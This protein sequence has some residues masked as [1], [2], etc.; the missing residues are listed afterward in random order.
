MLGVS[1]SEAV[2][3]LLPSSL[4]LSVVQ[5]HGFR[6]KIKI[7][8]GI[9]VYAIPFVFFGMSLSFDIKKNSFIVP[10]IGF[11]MLFLALLRI[12]GIER[13]SKKI[14]KFGR[15]S[16]VLTGFI[17]GISN[18]GGALLTI[19]M[20]S[21]Y[22][23]KERIRT[24]I[25]FAYLLFGLSQLIV[26]LWIKVETIGWLSIFYSLITLILYQL[27]GRHIFQSINL[28]LFNFVFTIFMV[29]YGLLL[30]ATTL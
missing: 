14:K 12:V 2:G 21:I 29:I 28:R 19:L 7:A 30:I 26:L 22:S 9:V 24:N 17:H 23:D 27:I 6:D 15:S 13:F 8:R 25:A 11:I 16:L 10:I 3:Y 5:A 18:Q 1:Y 4:A 20:G